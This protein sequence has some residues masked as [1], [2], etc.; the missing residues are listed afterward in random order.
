MFSKRSE[1]GMVFIMEEN[2]NEIKEEKKVE[3]KVKSEN[4]KKEEKTNTEAEK[5]IKKETGTKTASSTDADASKFK[6]VET[7]GSKVQIEKR[8]NIN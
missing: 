2:K 5:N 8:K 1:K 4:N 7:N 3:E 6:K